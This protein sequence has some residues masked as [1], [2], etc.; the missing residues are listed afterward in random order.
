MRLALRTALCA[1]DGGTPACARVLEL[2]ADPPEWVDLL[3]AGSV[4]ARDG[5]RW[6]V[7]D[8]EAVAAASRAR[9]G[10]TDLAIDYE[11]QSHQ[12]DGEAP[13]AA[14]IKEIKVEDGMIRGR[15][16]WTGHAAARIRA[17]E[18]RYL[19]PTFL[20]DAATGAVRA[21]T[22]AGLTNNPAL[23][24]PALATDQGGEAPMNE[25]QLKALREALCLAEDADAPAI[26]AA[27][28]AAVAG[29]QALA[30]VAEKVGLA[31]DAS[32]DDVLAAA[33]RAP[34]AGEFVPRSEFDALAARATALEA[35]AADE[36]A[37]AAVD[38]AVEAGK[39][40]PAQRDWAMAYAKS[41]PEGF[42][43]YVEATPAIVRPG[44]SGP[45]RPG[46]G[47]DPGAALTDEELAVCR[48]TGVSADDYQAA[49]KAQREGAAPERKPSE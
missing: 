21:V 16:D 18:Y 9:A 10:A 22:G 29:N 15:V 25:E 24:L 3:P 6:T 31:K 40:T 30:K 19:S 28:A 45:G 1:A 35:S 42:G 4:V 27:A 17:R 32:C 48:S 33:H 5:R 2:P 12:S 46:T 20:F 43:S 44:R 49:R 38:A 11:H 14:W 36:K 34:A 26:L 41:D 37:A 8:A 13:A 23:D 39:V 47:G 7:A